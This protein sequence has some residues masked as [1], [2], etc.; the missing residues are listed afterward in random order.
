V[1][2]DDGPEREGVLLVFADEFGCLVEA[3]LPKPE[4]AKARECEDAHRPVAPVEGA[5]GELELPSAS[6][7]RPVAV[8]TPPKVT[9]QKGNI[10]SYLRRRANSATK[11]VET[12]HSRLDLSRVD[13]SETC[14]SECSR[15]EIAIA[16][17]ARVGCGRVG[18]ALH[19]ERVVGGE[20]FEEVEPAVFGTLAGVAAEAFGARNPAAE[21]ERGVRPRGVA[22]ALSTG[23]GRFEDHDVA[24][25]GRANPVEFAGTTDGV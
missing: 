12:G 19:E 24:I 10:G 9:W 16:E 7:Q 14:E 8:R 22:R 23:R 17:A 15:L 4:V 21:G 2:A 20:T 3:T 6:A 1:E 13:G 25:F 18:V 5:H 11:R